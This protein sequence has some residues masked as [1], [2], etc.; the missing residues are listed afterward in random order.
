MQKKYFFKKKLIKKFKKSITFISI[1]RNL[2]IQKKIKLLILSKNKKNLFYSLILKLGNLSS[3]HV[4]KKKPKKKY[5]SLIFETKEYF[6]PKL[7]NSNKL[8]QKKKIFIKKNFLK[9]IKKKISNKKFLE[10]ALLDIVK[11]EKKKELDCLKKIFIL[12]KKINEF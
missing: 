11:K 9:Q 6:I 7:L 8:E 3:L 1:I 5:Y 12:K 10:H 2:R 4:L